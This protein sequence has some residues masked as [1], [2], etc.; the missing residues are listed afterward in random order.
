MDINKTRISNLPR[1]DLENIWK[2]LSPEELDE[3][4]FSS[5]KNELSTLFGHLTER[6]I[7]EV[8]QNLSSQAL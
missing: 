5:N 1:E 8:V 7:V 3:L 6:G 2:W 4:I